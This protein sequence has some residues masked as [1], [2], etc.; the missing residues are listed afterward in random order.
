MNENY[1]I[2]TDEVLLDKNLKANARLL[3]IKLQN[4]SQTKGYCFATNRYLGE[5]FGLTQSSISKLISVLK[6]AGYIRIEMIR[7]ELTNEITERRIFITKKTPK[8]AAEDVNKDLEKM[9]DSI[10][11]TEKKATTKKIDKSAKNEQIAHKNE[12]KTPKTEY[13][14][15]K[16]EYK[17]PKNEQKPT[18]KQLLK[19]KELGLDLS[20]STKFEAVKLIGEAIKK[21]KVYGNYIEPVFE[22]A[23]NNN[24]DYDVDELEKL[25]F[26]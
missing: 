17:K 4:L 7:G 26:A 13:K 9:S 3:F 11:K 14:K 12:V 19:A 1:N 25:L 18:E 8:K 22:S 20:K 16:T 6:K 15:P 24:N 2:V 21:T 10:K 5:L 23:K